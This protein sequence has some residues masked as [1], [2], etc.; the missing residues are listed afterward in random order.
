MKHYEPLYRD[1]RTPSP[2]KTYYSVETV[3]KIVLAACILQNY[4]MGMD[5][6]EQML[7]QVDE[8]LLENEPETK[9]V[10]PRVNDNED[11]RKGAAIRDEIAQSMWRDYLN[12]V[13]L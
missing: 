5:L 6:D 8:Q 3:T 1:A 7:R 13:G 4:L 10:Q 2:T 9:E 12:H 11:V